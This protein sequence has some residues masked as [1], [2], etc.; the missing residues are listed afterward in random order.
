MAG[1]GLPELLALGPA[2]TAAAIAHLGYPLYLMR[3]LGLAK[4]LGLGHGGAYERE[5]VGAAG[6]RGGVSGDVDEERTSHDLDRS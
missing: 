5:G 2:S 6:L 1:S 3:I 4:V